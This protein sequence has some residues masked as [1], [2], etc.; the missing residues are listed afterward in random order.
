MSS[1]G[2]T[3]LV[4]AGVTTLVVAGVADATAE[5]LFPES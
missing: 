4:I 1:D 5:D 2:V 3:T